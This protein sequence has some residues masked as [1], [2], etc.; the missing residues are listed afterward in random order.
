MAVFVEKECETLLKSGFESAISDWNTANG[1]SYDPS[2]RRFWSDDAS[3]EDEEKIIFPHI[4]IGA[5]PNTPQGYQEPLRS[6]PVTVTIATLVIEDRK[7]ETLA[8]IYQ[9]IREAVDSRNFNQ[10][11]TELHN[12]EVT[13]FDGGD[14][15]EDENGSYVNLNLTLEVCTG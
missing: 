4:E 1:T 13:A 10:D 14:I 15:L 11:T 12:V 7:R 3:N 8:G 6:V 9:A 5:S 2:Y